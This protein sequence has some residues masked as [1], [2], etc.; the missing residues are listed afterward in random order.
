MLD[1]DAF[2][3]YPRIFIKSP[4]A[5]FKLLRNF[6]HL[7]RNL[8]V[9]LRELSAN[10]YTAI[11]IYLV[12]YCSNSLER[13][14]FKIYNYHIFEHLQ[15]PFDKL[16]VLAVQAKLE[17]GQRNSF[18][19]INE[20]N[21]PNLQSLCLSAYRI[22]QQD[23]IHHKNVEYLTVS[24]V[25]I[26]D[27]PFSFENLKYL[28]LGIMEEI[29]DTL[30]QFIGQMKNLKII[31]LIFSYTICECS[32][33]L[34]RLLNLQNIS[35]NVEE[36]ELSSEIVSFRSESIE[37]VFRFMKRS[38]RVRKVSFDLFSEI[39]PADVWLQEQSL[40]LK[41]EWKSYITPKIKCSFKSKYFVLERL[42]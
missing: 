18:Q 17:L 21:L 38:Q 12:E 24:S 36:I 14:A 41:D 8:G 37:T 19:F 33:S 4:L 2:V 10:I 5:L 31:R 15:K 3:Q 11:E 42:N 35:T 34:D 25:H 13:F 9:D 30:C 27:F 22:N 29:N 40:K 20:I 7:I 32:D 26:I 16:I 39:H 1:T 23:R 6:G 28:F